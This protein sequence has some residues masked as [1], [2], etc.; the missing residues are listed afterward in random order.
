MMPLFPRVPVSTKFLWCLSR[1]CFS[2]PPMWHLKNSIL[3]AFLHSVKQTKLKSRSWLR[4]SEAAVHEGDGR[5]AVPAEPAQHHPEEVRG[6]CEESR[7]LPVSRKAYYRAFV[8]FLTAGAFVPYAFALRLQ[9]FS[10]CSVP[11]PL[12]YSQQ[13]ALNRFYFVRVIEM[14]YLYQSKADELSLE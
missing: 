7:L 8:N 6:G 9:G 3:S 11:P 1:S 2:H 12:T 4:A 5:P 14:K 10:W 13:I